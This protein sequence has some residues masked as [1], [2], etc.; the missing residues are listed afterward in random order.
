MRAAFTFALGAA[1]AAP[2]FAENGIKANEIVLGQSASL[3]GGAAESGQQMRDGAN[4]Y[5]ELVN[6]KGGVNGRKIRLISLV[7]RSSRAAIS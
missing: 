2:V 6:R 3:T 1:L 7:H 4:A 5:F